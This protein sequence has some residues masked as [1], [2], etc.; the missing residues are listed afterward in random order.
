[1]FL[2]V[3]LFLCVCVCVFLCVC[4]CVRVCVCVCVCM[5]VYV[6]LCLCLCEYVCVHIESR[7]VRIST[8]RQTI[9]KLYVRIAR[10]NISD[11]NALDAQ[12]T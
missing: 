10:E 7:L 11:R 8:Y 3:V 9:H 2:C 4:V 1:V 12:L 5:C 6:C